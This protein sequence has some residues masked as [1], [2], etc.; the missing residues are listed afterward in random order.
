MV[1]IVAAMLSLGHDRSAIPVMPT[2][3]AVP[4]PI[5]FADPNAPFADPDIDA[6][7]YDDRH[8]DDD[9]RPGQHRHRQKRNDKQG[10]GNFLHGTLLGRDARRPD[11]R[12]HKRAEL[13][14][15]V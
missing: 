8:V 12:L 4:M 2:H 13:D 1:A 14:E 9:C 6:L 7:R 3:I 11:N 15:S 5:S 10:K